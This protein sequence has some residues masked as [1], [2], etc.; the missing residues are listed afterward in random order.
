M[1][2]ADSLGT[3]LGIVG[4]EVAVAH[5]AEEALAR[6]EEFRPRACVLD[7]TMPG[8]DGC[9]LARRIRAGGGADVLLIAL[10]ALGDYNSIERI[11]DAGFDLYFTKPVA[12]RDLYAALNDFAARGRPRND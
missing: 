6:A 9:E 5:G 8:M 4:C 7:I 11:A 12:A 10:T 3:L 1:D 2:A